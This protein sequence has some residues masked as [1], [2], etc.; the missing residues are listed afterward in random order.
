MANELKITQ[1]DD[2][3]FN[4]TAATG[5]AAAPMDLTGATL[6]TLIQGRSYDSAHHAILNQTTN[7]GQYTLTLSA[8]ET[9]LLK[10]ASAQEIITQCSQGGKMTQLHGIGVLQVLSPV[11][12]KN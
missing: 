6:T 5:S 12:N 3:V 9:A 7:K 1:G 4:L 8:A 2:V 11:P 10:V